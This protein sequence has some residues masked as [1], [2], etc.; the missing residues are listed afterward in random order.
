MKLNGFLE[1]IRADLARVNSTM[2]AAQPAA[3]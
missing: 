2:P 3:L 1:K